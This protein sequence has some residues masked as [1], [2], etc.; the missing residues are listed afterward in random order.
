MS[1]FFN[2]NEEFNDY[3]KQQVKGHRM[4]PADN[5]WRNIQTA[6]HGDYSWHALPVITIFI[7]AALTAGTLLTKPN[8]DLHK[9]QY[10]P[11]ISAS[12]IAPTEK[13][14]KVSA[15]ILRQNLSAENITQQTISQAAENLCMNDINKADIAYTPLPVDDVA[16]ELASVKTQPSFQN[17]FAKINA[18]V[19][20]VAF[21]SAKTIINETSAREENNTYINNAII[22]DNVFSF[23]RPISK[24]QGSFFMQSSLSFNYPYTSI[25]THNSI[26]LNLRHTIFSSISNFHPKPKTPKFSIQI[27]ATP[28]VSY[29]RLIDASTGH[30]AQSVIPASAFAQSNYGIDVNQGAHNTPALGIEAGFAVGYKITDQITLKTGLQFNMRQY[31]IQAYNYKQTPA[32]V[33]FA[34]SNLADSTN[35]VANPGTSSTGGYT[36]ILNNRYYEIAIPVGID[37]KATTF[38]KFFVGIA[39]FAQPT[40]TFDRQPFTITTDLK[41]YTNGSSLIRRWNLNTSAEAYIAYKTGAYTWQ[42]GPQFR[43]QQLPSLTGQYPIKE[44]LLDYGIKFGITKSIK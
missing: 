4:Y 17:Y 18:A 43:Y 6:L 35:L 10:H 42:L 33:G 16:S 13:Q 24:K 15:E 5:L 36:T 25:Y 39:G 14:N 20:T 23:M 29:R 41:N 32:S 7:I 30:A 40:Y 27:Y 34:S 22:P 11:I 44:Y 19:M 3:L 31:N 38:N 12:S 37:W 26:K 21:A 8:D 2:D 1:E 9:S 28:S